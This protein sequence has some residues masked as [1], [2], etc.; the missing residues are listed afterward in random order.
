MSK[1]GQSWYHFNKIFFSPFKLYTLHNL[2][3]A[4]TIEC[5]WEKCAQWPWTKF[6][7]VNVKQ[8]FTIP[9]HPEDF[10]LKR[11]PLF[12]NDTLPYFMPLP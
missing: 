9:F 2:V 1:Q 5:P 4:L 7:N 10:Y 6:L 12:L 3:H 11:N 8:L